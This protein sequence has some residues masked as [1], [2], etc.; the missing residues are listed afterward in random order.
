MIVP[1][2][3]TQQVI[4]PLPPHQTGASAYSLGLAVTSTKM[5]VQISKTL[6]EEPRVPATTNALIIISWLAIVYLLQDV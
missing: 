1:A 2:K 3:N 4:P 6:P 5:T